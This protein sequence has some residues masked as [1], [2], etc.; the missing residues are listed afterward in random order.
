MKKEVL[1]EEKKDHVTRQLLD[2]LKKIKKSMKMTLTSAKRETGRFKKREISS[3]KNHRKE[4]SELSKAIRE[5][6]RELRKAERHRGEGSSG[7]IVHNLREEVNLLQAQQQ[8]LALLDSRIASAYRLLNSE[9]AQIRT[10]IITI[11]GREKQILEFDEKLKDME[12]DL[13][14]AEKTLVSLNDNFNKEIKDIEKSTNLYEVA[15]SSTDLLSHF[16]KEVESKITI[17]ERFD[18]TMTALLEESWHIGKLSQKYNLLIKAA[19]RSEEAIDNGLEYL[20]RMVE[21]IVGNEAERYDEK[22]LERK[23]KQM[24]KTIAYVI[25]IDNHILSIEQSIEKQNMDEYKYMK[26]LLNF[27]KKLREMLIKTSK[28]IGIVMGH[29]SAR[30]VDIDKS[31]M[32]KVNTF[33]AQLLQRNT[34]ASRAFRAAAENRFN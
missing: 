25:N 23:I 2:S 29:A 16:I 32:K 26:E 24:D 8:R 21:A 9:I 27:D 15:L 33:N 22:G 11:Q 34:D 20:S 1:A 18:E 5:K 19:L 30:K 28:R 13:M 12:K 17:S 7:Q 3:F 6:E 4:F 14:S 10:I 31:E